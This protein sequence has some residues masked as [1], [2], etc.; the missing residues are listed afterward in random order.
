MNI[1][2]KWLK[3]AVEFYKLELGFEFPELQPVIT[4][5]K[6][7]LTPAQSEIQKA[8]MEKAKAEGKKEGKE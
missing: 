5:I 2:S 3:V 8:K 1:I 6:E 4:K 7:L